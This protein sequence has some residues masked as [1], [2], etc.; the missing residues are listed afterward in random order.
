M[1]LFLKRLILICGVICLALGTGLFSPPPALAN[2]VGSE[3]IA[4]EA[5]R[6]DS[7]SGVQ[8]A[9]DTYLAAIPRGYYT[10]KTVAE[11]KAKLQ[12]EPVVL[13]DV[14]EASEYTA[15]HLRG[16]VNIPLRSLTQHLDQ[17]PQDRPVVLYCSTGYRTAMGVM[18]LQML[19]YE[20]VQGFPPSLE[21]WKRA[22]EPLA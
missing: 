20:N 22:G 18:A 7:Q 5:P 13:V 11:L 16:A 2:T 3:G 4:L 17:I 1:F 19:G 10:V 8:S 12:K 6:A 9:L 14:R 15:G 21:G